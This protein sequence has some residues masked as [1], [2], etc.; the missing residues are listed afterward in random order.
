MR[1][2]SFGHL[3]SHCIIHVECASD[4]K[5]MSDDGIEALVCDDDMVYP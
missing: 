1:W 2:T 5:T 4:L 3:I